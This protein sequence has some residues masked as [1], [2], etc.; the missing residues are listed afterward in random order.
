M[1]WS[2]LLVAGLLE[3]CWAVGLKYTDGF[4]RLVP[5]ALTL[6]AMLASVYCLALALRTI[7]IGTGYAV[8]TGIGAVGTALFGVVF[9]AEPA[10][11]ARLGSIGLILVGIV[12]L[13]LSAGP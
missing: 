11:L 5:T 10:T 6:G 8:W 9:L 7:P 3:I 1:A 12:G 2:Y 4:S 13:R